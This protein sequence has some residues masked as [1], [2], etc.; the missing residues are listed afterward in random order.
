MKKNKNIW[1]GILALVFAATIGAVGCDLFNPPDDNEKENENNNNNNNNGNGVTTGTYGD[2]TYSEYSNSVSITGY[3]GTGGNVTIPSQINN[4]PVTSIGNGAFQKNTS[5]TSVIIP[6]SVIIIN[7]WAFNSCTSLA[8]VTIP[9]SVTNIGGF[10]FQSTNLT[11]VTI[12]SK[13]PVIAEATFDSCVKLTSV[14][15]QGTDITLATKAFI[16]DINTR[17]LRSTYEAGGVGTY[18]KPNSNSSTWT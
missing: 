16:D 2:F 18:T 9:D 14:T 5:L 13:V 7:S 12:P 4:K 10:S 8:S 3:T 1:L 17:S 11:S 15:F 6:N